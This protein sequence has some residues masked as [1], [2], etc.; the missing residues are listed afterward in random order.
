MDGNDRM[1]NARGFAN[2][3]LPL[4]V[5][6]MIGTATY[7]FVFPAPYP[8]PAITSEAAPDFKLMAEAWNSI[9]R[10]YVD[11]SAVQ[12]RR[13]TYGAISGMVESLG[14]TGHSTFLTPEMVQE[15]R[16]FEK[17]EFA[18]IGAEVQVKNKQVVI[19]AP[20]DGSPAQK[21]GLRPGD[22]IVQ[23]DG[24]DVAGLSLQQTVAKILGPAGT[25]V[26]L[27]IRDPATSREWTVSITR[28]TIA[29]QSVTW[30]MLPG[31][32][33]AHLRI[34][35]FSKGT[36]QAL[37]RALADLQQRGAK[38]LVLDLRNDPGGLLA[39]A[40]GVASRFLESGTVLQEKNAK[41][42]IRAVPVERGAPKCA[43]PMAVLI[44]AGTAS[45]SEIVAGALQ[46]AKR[47]ILVGETT[48]G[49]GTVLNPVPLS[50]GSALLLAVMEWLTPKGRIIWHKG[51]APDVAVS[52]PADVSPLVPDA[53]QGMTPQRLRA[54]NDQQLL[55]ALDLLL[56]KRPLQKY[57]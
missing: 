57:D 12:P 19:V 15:E 47:A 22:I 7:R 34:A 29:L 42:E 10:D 23:V 13:M 55:R 50:D 51:I 14:D 25:R 9:E 27:T 3:I 44:N 40:V 26:T 36:S 18:G 17:G 2:W 20:M 49:T 8:S 48:F 32:D 16:T 33:R 5:G 41:G 30:R 54:S 6:F 56:D 4:L 11:R 38:G 46:D 45:A 31:T 52:L 39:M 37:D 28:A 24:S 1:N 43:L 21:A 35:F 53:E